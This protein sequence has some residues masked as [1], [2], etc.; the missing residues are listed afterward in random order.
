MPRRPD[1]EERRE[2][3][4]ALKKAGRAVARQLMALDEAALR[5]R[6]HVDAALASDSCDHSLRATRAWAQSNSLEPEA[7]AVSLAHF[8][9]YCDCEVVTNVRAEEIFG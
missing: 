3:T 6:D 2:L 5:T 4:R 1:R 7:L 8:G 9:G